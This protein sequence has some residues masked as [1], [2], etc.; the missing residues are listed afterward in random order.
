MTIEVAL[1]IEGQN[2]LT[3]P[4]WQRLV[5]AAE[6]LGFVGLYRSD[7]FTNANPPEK[8]SLE[9]W[10]SLTWLASQ[11]KRIE[12]GP[13]VSPVSFRHPA[14]TARIAAA[15]DDLSGGRLQLG[16]GAGWQERE[17]SMF[18]FDLLAVGPRFQRFREGLEV[19]TRLLRGDKPV[20]WIGEYY[21]LR[22]AILL[23]RP[24]RSG[25][26]P[27]VIGGNGEQRTLPLA[28]RYADEWNAVFVPPARFAE[29]NARL[30]TLLDAAGRP[31]NTVRRSLM[32][33]SVFGRDEREVERL[34]AGRS[35]AQLRDRGILVGVASE[36]VEQ[37][38]A[39]AAVGVERIMVQWLDLDDLDRLTAFANRVLPQLA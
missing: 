1:M 13:L 31:R 24:L 34:L 9:L 7:H 38:A 2:G 36:I 29:L 26:P 18:G 27:I 11:T 4:R 5:Q 17:H 22:E 28:A 23:P 32:I 8:E 20:T 14:L 3:W 39:F 21:Q 10:V 6:D 37:I 25:G 15:V 12:F 33:G 30:D 19:I 16:L 35:R